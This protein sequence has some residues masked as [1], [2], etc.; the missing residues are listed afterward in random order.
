MD[1]DDMDEM[2]DD[3][4]FQFL[5]GRCRATEQ[6]LTR[7]IEA[8]QECSPRIQ[9]LA[10][11]LKDP[12]LEVELEKETEDY[13]LRGFLATATMMGHHLKP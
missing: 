8:L 1:Y 12:E 13:E 3:Q 11:E 4:R 5:A 10:D 7:L 2:S 6:Y 9:S